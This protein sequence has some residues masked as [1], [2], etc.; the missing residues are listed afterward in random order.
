VQRVHGFFRLN[1][2]LLGFPFSQRAAHFIFQ[3]IETFTDN[4]AAFV[5]LLW[6]SLQLSDQVFTCV[7]DVRF[8]RA[9][10]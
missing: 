9:T 10:L 1:A 5:D 7:V 2:F 8:E 4:A 6:Q 3:R